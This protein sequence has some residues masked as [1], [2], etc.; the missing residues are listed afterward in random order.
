[1]KGDK[2][3]AGPGEENVF[4]RKQLEDMAL[5]LEDKISELSIIREMGRGL[6][7]IEDFRKTVE[8]ILEVVISNTRAQNFSIMLLE[9]ETDRL[10]LAAASDPRNKQYV[11]PVGDLVS[12]E[13]LRYSF[14]HGQGIA[15]TVLAKGEA[16]LVDDTKKSADF[17]AESPSEI[18]IGSLLSVPLFY[19][20]NSIGVV[21]LSHSQ[22]NIFTRR[23]LYLFSILADFIAL[24]LSCSLVH[25]RLRASEEKYRT[26][27]ENSND[28]IAI[29]VD[30]KHVYANPRYQS[31][32]GYSAAELRDKT[33]DELLYSAGLEHD[34][35]FGASQ[36]P[37]EAGGKML[38]GI[39]L[40]RDDKQLEIE[41]NSAA[42]E[43]NGEPAT[44]IS[45][46]DLSY[47]RHLEKQ[48]RQFQ[49]MEAIG[50]L[51]GGVAHDFNNILSAIIGYTELAI[52]KSQRS[53]HV[54]NYLQQI[55]KAGD[56]AKS[57]V[58]QILTF[59]RQS[60]QEEEIVVRID[61]IAKEVL[62]LLRAAIPASIEIQHDIAT[63]C[64][65]RIDPILIHQIL[66][67]ISINAS[68]A[69]QENG[70]LLTV[71]L[72][73]IDPDPNQLKEVQIPVNHY[74]RLS[75]QDTGHG[76][77][78]AIQD[79]IFE[80]YFTTKELGVGTG[81]GLSVVLGIVKS[82]KGYI[83]VESAP[84]KG[85]RFD[86]YLPRIPQDRM[87]V[88]QEEQEI[89]TGD[90]RVLLVDD[91]EALVYM[92]K[93]LLS[94]LGYGVVAVNTSQQALEMVRKEPDRFDLVITDQG[95]PRMKGTR[96]AQEIHTVRP[97][98]PI[99]LCTGFSEN[100][101]ESNAQK[102]GIRKILMKPV[103][104]KEISS[105]IRE[106]LDSGETSRSSS[107]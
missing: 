36:K 27:T 2:K 72:T 29:L 11:V 107:S 45:I 104:M 75:I 37:A 78:E 97:E 59:S 21:N 52:R 14:A 61:L 35:T 76:M 54:Y 73:K 7:H 15:G 53:N 43:H 46:R 98:L 66:M 20:G 103:T 74:V 49:K 44:L 58:K 70:G 101:T 57:L 79:R 64:Y 99:I 3:A 24:L 91:E 8:I 12:R 100:L 90:E 18:K 9:P 51:A 65:V 33:F 16:M 92:L 96:L 105:S 22:P 41:A 55:M 39:L 50:T 95:M 94:L 26:L 88:G 38:K 77:D 48:L 19:E 89:A 25:Q 23:D 31:M 68:H 83:K 102:I 106:V 30:K 56:R 13:N 67:N 32:T 5:R 85:A 42:I 93:E 6:A 84:G 69:M 40:T 86:I 17:S 1:M 82:H 34:F 80:P 71:S 81:M 63:D 47:R 62:R 28:G 87:D 10:F 4:L 60:E